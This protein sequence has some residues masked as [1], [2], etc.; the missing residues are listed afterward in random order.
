MSIVITG[1]NGQVGW[2]LCRQAK[3]KGLAIHGFDRSQLDITDSASVAET[4]KKCRPHVVVNAAAYTQVDQAETDSKQAFEVNQQG[5]SYLA[6]CCA[7]SK[8]P[9]IH[10]STDYVFDGSADSPYRENDALSPLGIYG[11]SKAAGEEEVRCRLPQHVIVRTSWVY[12]VHGNNFVKT[13]LRLGNERDVIG[14]VNDQFGCPTSARD[15]ADTILSMANQIQSGKMPTWGTYHY[16]GKGII[17]W[18]DFAEEIFRIA[19]QYGYTGSPKV[20]AITT[21]EYPTTVKRPAFSALNCDRL[22]HFFQISP[23]PW[24]ESIAQTL[25]EILS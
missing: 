6:A 23:K 14:V 11:R 4:V 2:E 21:A 13:M 17:S 10:I 7:E 18:F 5:P 15:I 9:L 24:Q 25:K 16:C 1:T 19:K 22:L 3:M 8:I 12:G 20:N